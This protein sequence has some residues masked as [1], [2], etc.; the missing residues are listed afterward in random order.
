MFYIKLHES[1]LIIE[2]MKKGIKKYVYFLF[3]GG[4]PITLYI[5]CCSLGVMCTFLIIIL[6]SLRILLSVRTHI[7][8]SSAIFCFVLNEEYI[9][10]NIADTISNIEKKQI[11][12]E[13]PI[14]S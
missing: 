9:I 7:P 8:Y 1:T 13:Y 11:I 2:L 3:I 4:L 12:D 5:L 10:N 6:F 14:N